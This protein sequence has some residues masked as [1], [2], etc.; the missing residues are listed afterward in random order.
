MKNKTLYICKFQN[1]MTLPERK[2]SCLT[3][4]HAYPHEHLDNCDGDC[5]PN[6]TPNA[7]D[8]QEHMTCQ[9]IYD[10]KK[11]FKSMREQVLG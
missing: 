3:C 11:V 8:I 4:S 5:C 6:S 2:E 9:P 10:K 1:H 7:Y